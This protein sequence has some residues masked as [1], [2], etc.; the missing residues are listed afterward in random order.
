M[1][2][3]GGNTIKKIKH[4]L[5]EI[6]FGKGWKSDIAFILLILIIYK[7][8]IENIL[9]IVLNTS[10]PLVIVATNSMEHE[11]FDINWYLNNNFTL[12]EI[13]NFP[14][15]D[16]INIG[17]LV[18]VKGVKCEELKRGDVAVYKTK[19]Y[20]YPIVHRIVKIERINNKCYITFKGDNN[21]DILHFER[22]VSMENI[23]G[24][25]IFRIPYI[26][27]PKIFLLKTFGMI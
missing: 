27:L 3:P 24:K 16:G 14:F 20:K 23:V 8:G 22:N 25:V 10:H 4:T 17:D 19:Y 1:D 18:I 5:K 13:E 12:E 2:I 21:Q 9:K 7:F 26:G 15:K 11:N 6:F